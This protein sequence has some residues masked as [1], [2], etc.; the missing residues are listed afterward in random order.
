[1]EALRPKGGTVVSR[2]RGVKHPGNAPSST[3]REEQPKQRAMR[4]L[5]LYF[6]AVTWLLQS[7]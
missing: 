3:A 5:A 6:S 4:G 2:R 1:M 7:Q